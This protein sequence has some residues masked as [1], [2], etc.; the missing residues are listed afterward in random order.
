[1]NQTRVLIADSLP[2]FRSGVLT[3][4]ERES[5]FD[6]KAVS[7]FHSFARAIAADCPDIAIVDL[8]LPPN[9]G[10]DAVSHVSARCSCH[11]IVWSFD[12]TRET[13]LAAV[14]AGADG[15]LDKRISQAGFLRALR[16][17]SHGEAPLSRDLA[18]MMID[19]L[20]GL[21]ERSRAREKAHVLSFREREVLELVADG[22]KNKEVAAQLVISEFTVKRH[23][24]NILHKLELPSR[25]AAASFYRLA[26]GVDE[27]AAQRVAEVV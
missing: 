24:Q 10:V 2:I 13:V 25:R 11:T 22:A 26:F 21:E 19:A 20:H 6:V 8:D 16:G 17:V 18:S 5:D 9:G 4:L 14:R 12:P 3:L 7:D 15:Y 23:I 27:P 1:M